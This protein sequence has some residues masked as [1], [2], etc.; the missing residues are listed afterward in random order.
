MQNEKKHWVKIENRAI[1]LLQAHRTVAA[2]GHL[3][4]CAKRTVARLLRDKEDTSYVLVW[5]KWIPPED[6]NISSETRLSSFWQN[7]SGPR[8]EFLCPTPIHNDEYF[9]S[10][11]VWLCVWL[12]FRICGVCQ[13]SNE[14][15]DFYVKLTE[16]PNQWINPRN[17]FMMIDFI[18]W[19]H[20]LM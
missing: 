7:Y 18:T 19:F 4:W 5:G 9:F 6:Q 1:G 20:I 15:L 11:T 14:K 3:P 12:S 2:V 16:I 10:P 13:F 8:M 17:C